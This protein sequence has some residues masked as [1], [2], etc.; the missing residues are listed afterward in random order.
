MF[1]K[2]I[3]VHVDES[4]QS[5]ERVRLAAGLAAEQQAHLVGIAITGITELLWQNAALE[6]SDPNLAAYFDALR[7]RSAAALAQFEPSVRNLGVGS[8]ESVLTDDDASSGFIGRARCSDLCILGQPEPGRRLTVSND[9]TESALQNSGRPTLIVPHTGHFAYTGRRI[10]IAWDGGVEAADHL[11]QPAGE[12]DLQD[13]RG[14]EVLAQRRPR[15]VVDRLHE[16][17]LPAE[18]DDRRLVGSEQP[19]G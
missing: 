11:V 10:L 19:L 8:C 3:L 6:Y 5:A 17:G 18:D 4:T 15:R 9:F 12:G 14:G 16:C 7:E 13:L 1:Y 2:T